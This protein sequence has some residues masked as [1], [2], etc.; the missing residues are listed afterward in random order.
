MVHKGLRLGF[1][2]GFRRK[3]EL[4]KSGMINSEPK[5]VLWC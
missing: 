3:A 5:V 4:V 1:G 2:E